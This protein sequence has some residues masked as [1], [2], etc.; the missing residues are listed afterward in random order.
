MN[1]SIVT[2]NNE[3]DRSEYYYYNSV[4]LPLEPFN[5]TDNIPPRNWNGT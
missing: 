5:L 3:N 4:E 2:Y 1:P